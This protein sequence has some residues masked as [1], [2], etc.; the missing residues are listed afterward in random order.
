MLP[1]AR[2]ASPRRRSAAAAA[3][4]G[5]GGSSLT[6]Y[7]RRDFDPD[8]RDPQTFSRIDA[9]QTL[10]DH[11]MALRRHQWLFAAIA[12][13]I[14]CSVAAYV[15]TSTPLYKSTLQMLFEEKPPNLVNLQSIIMGSLQ[16]EGAFLGEIEILKS[17]K[18]AGRVIQKL[19]LE[20][21]PEFNL[22]LREKNPVA[23]VR[24][25]IGAKLSQ[26]TGSSS[27]GQSEVDDR[28]LENQQLVDAFLDR[29]DVGP[30]GRSRVV[31]VAFTS[32]NPMNAARIANAVAEQYLQMQ[33]ERSF[34]VSRRASNWLTGR[35]DEMRSQVEEADR[36]IA[37]YR[38]TF[39]LLQ[40]QQ[41]EPLINE[42]ISN[43]NIKL[44]EASM[45]RIKAEA[46]LGQVRR[47]VA[48]RNVDAVAKVLE[49]YPGPTISRAGTG[50][51]A[52]GS[53]TNQ[54]TGT[55]A[56]PGHTVAS[57]EAA[58][59][60][61]GRSGSAEA[62]PK[63]GKRGHR[64]QGAGESTDRPTERCQGGAV[65]GQSGIRD[66][67][68][69]GAQRRI[70]QTPAREILNGTIGARRT[71]DGRHSGR[72]GIRHVAGGHS[73]RTVLPQKRVAAGRRA[74]RLA[75]HR[76]DRRFSDRAR[77]RHLP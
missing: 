3:E 43:L 41:N 53:G 23:L 46:S 26:Y 30:T 19:T 49:I 28:E 67:Q 8:F 75:A 22:Q 37:A 66:T 5:K 10:K 71:G 73:D 13:L 51:G 15:F 40:G 76:V 62:C 12:T 47:D 42:Q 20:T 45:D 6:P 9:A 21:D 27:E 34:E 57:R 77:R 31:E 44:T 69:L 25:W 54:G 1:H 70:R 65:L 35:I 48:S 29:L 72:D 33:F 32:E 59:S 50:V 56:S 17:R 39:G 52:E 24:A 16:D 2:S 64:R 4:E 58:V 14:F 74:G 60:G 11:L 18:L 36:T 61:D 55:A 68:L 63:S 7:S 38:G